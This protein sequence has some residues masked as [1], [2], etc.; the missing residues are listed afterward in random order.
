MD[1]N[2]E[3]RSMKN[4]TIN[5]E[6]ENY[7]D[8]GFSFKDKIPVNEKYNLSEIYNKKENNDEISEI[9]PN[10]DINQFNI[11][12]EIKDPDKNKN[13]N[14]N[15]LESNKQI[16]IKNNQNNIINEKKIIINEN[17]AKD[18]ENDKNDNNIGNPSIS[19]KVKDSN[20]KHLDVYEDIKETNSILNN[21][22][23]S[24]KDQ[25][26]EDKAQKKSF[27]EEIEKSETE[28][29]EKFK[30][31]REEL[32]NYSDI[33]FNDE[34]NYTLP[35]KNIMNK[36]PLI[37]LNLEEAEEEEEEDKLFSV[38]NS[39]Y[40]KDSLESKLNFIMEKKY[41]KNRLVGIKDYLKKKCNNSSKFEN[42]IEYFGESPFFGCSN[43]TK[44]I[45]F[46]FYNFEKKNSNNI[47]DFE[48]MKNSTIGDIE[49][50]TGLLYKYKKFKNNEI[51][52]E[53]EKDENKSNIDYITS[54]LKEL[55]YNNIT[56]FENVYFYRKVMN[57][58]NSFYR[59]FMF[60][61]IEI[62]I[63]HNKQNLYNLYILMKIISSNYKNI[64]FKDI[65]INYTR[66]L[67]RL[68]EIL[69]YL[70]RYSTQ[71][72]LE[73]FYNSFSLSCTYFD[74]FLI[75][76]LKFILYYSKKKILSD[77]NYE[78]IEFEI[79]DLFLLPYIFDISLEISFDIN[80]GENQF[81]VF[82]TNICKN[83]LPLK[84]CFYKDNTFIYYNMDKYILFAKNNMIK[85]YDKIPKINKIIYKFENKKF[86][87]NC[88][89]ETC[90]IALIEKSIRICENCLKIYID[91]II[92][93]RIKLLPK[94]YFNQNIF[95]KSII[96]KKEQYFLED[97]EFLYLYNENIIDS[98][99]K[100][101]F[102]LI[103]EENIWFCSKCKQLLRN[104]KKLKCGC[105]YCYD[106]LH[107]IINKMT[108]EYM[109][110]NKYE[111]KFV[112]KVR[113]QCG[114]NMDILA[115]IEDEEEK[116]KNNKYKKNYKLMIERLNEYIKTL[117]M[118][119]EIK[120]FDNN[121]TDKVKVLNNKNEQITESHIL[122]KKCVKALRIKEKNKIKILCKICSENHDV[123]IE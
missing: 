27:S 31:L 88:R 66:C 45:D 49:H 23:I 70:E 30:Y 110:L 86:C 46:S 20:L 94:Y 40:D 61:L 64:I 93:K 120:I 24:E 111:K 122:C 57:D 1:N 74:D 33:Y 28:I 72:A 14:E 92:Q 38:I 62:Y 48:F 95:S 104:T 5:R 6:N 13:K 44:K 102:Y 21:N 10:Y 52:I 50:F 113:C 18:N 101:I 12:D 69:C 73:L 105:Y 112:G 17:K 68:E 42:Y 55:G 60:G 90:R 4:T 84:L 8:E 9:E 35:D 15:N 91:K 82:D 71:E 65:E 109:I 75:I 32:I 22:C 85:I 103:N 7:E 79:Y 78:V 26:L 11:N 56:K 97:Y 100:K 2:N 80:I 117:C 116:V 81:L 34:E 76:F 115:V 37:L 54:T 96:L 3:S 83:S 107:N 51:K 53:K 16:I 114:D 19:E 108:N 36:Y 41:I 43:I 59:A 29:Q 63:L 106:C 25:K 119:C 121:N 87:Q 47:K 58:G 123:T 67:T 98:I 77:F 39:Y 118:N 99:Q 89:S